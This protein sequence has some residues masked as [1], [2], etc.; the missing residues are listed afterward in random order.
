[1]NCPNC[2]AEISDSAKTCPKCGTEIKH[3]YIWLT[4][5]NC[6]HVEEIKFESGST[7]EK[8]LRNEIWFEDTPENRAK[9]GNYL[10]AIKK[11][12]Y[13]SYPDENKPEW[14]TMDWVNNQI[15]G[16]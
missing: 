11:A 9:V 3:D 2:K 8:G 7:F 4:I 16:D 5:P 12:I 13:Y 6:S 10:N 15:K 1:M 14:L